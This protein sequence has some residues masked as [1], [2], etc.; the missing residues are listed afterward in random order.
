VRRFGLVPCWLAGMLLAVAAFVG[1]WGL[2]PGLHAE[3]VAVCVASGLALGAD[4]ALPGALLTGLVHRAGHGARAEGVY[5]GWWTSATK[6]NL[7]LA[8]GLAL[9]L[10]ALA[11]YVPGTRDA[12]SLQALAFAYVAVPCVL[13]LAAAAV[14]WRWWRTGSGVAA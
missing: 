7:G 5:A 1:A 12:D 3:F 11:G 6:I 4:L 8:A 13:K 9:P 10:L 2:G 14:L